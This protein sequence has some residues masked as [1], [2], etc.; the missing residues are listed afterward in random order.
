MTKMLETIREKSK[1]YRCVVSNRLMVSPMMAADG[2]YYEQSI[3]QAQPSISTERAIPHPKLKAK[4]AEFSKDSLKALE[5]LL[6]QKEP[7]Q[8]V[9]DI[10][11]ECLSVLNLEADLESVLKVLG[12]VEGEGVKELTRRLR[13]LVPVE[14]LLTLMNQTV[15]QLPYL[16]LCL[17]ELS[18]L[19]PLSE[20]IFELALSCFTEQL[21]QA[22]LIPGVVSVVE[23]ISGR[24][25]SSQLGQMN[26]ALGA[27]PREREVEDKLEKLKLKEAY[28]RL[29]EGD[30]ETAVSL[31][32]TLHN[33][34][35]LEEEVLKFYE[36]AGMPSAKLTILK[37]KLSAS[38]EALRQESPSVAATISI[39]YQLF[40]TQLLTLRTETATQE[41]FTSLRTEVGALRADVAKGEDTARQATTNQE[42]LI[43]E[44]VNH[45]QST[46]AGIQKSFTSLKAE[47]DEVHKAWTNARNEAKQAQTAQSAFVSKLEAQS[48]RT[49]AAT[50]FSLANLRAEI[51]VLQTATAKAESKAKQV[52]ANHEAIIQRLAELLQKTE[53][54][55]GEMGKCQIPESH[56]R[57]IV[58]EE[59][60]PR[61]VKALVNMGFSEEQSREALMRAQNDV[62]LALSMLFS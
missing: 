42:A 11:A 32:S 54:R 53:Q 47:V 55:I 27:H 37:H 20:K 17:A 44:L 21:N 13:D 1:R 45:F 5:G 15:R 30:R 51:V 4:I 56:S 29:R 33:S 50:K 41:S 16:A 8:G 46:A 60:M 2:N 22:Y 3:L 62:N 9:Y 14:Y 48:N 59:E 57:K 52:E 39:V 43:Q 26:S 34:P 49:E 19:E 24:L 40:D 36:E 31:V 7:L 61:E 18:L 23:E 12:A 38:L 58:H 6:K 28:L 35:R 10:T 25:S